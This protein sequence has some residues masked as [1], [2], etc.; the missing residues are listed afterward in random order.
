MF[1]RIGLS[2]FKLYSG[3]IS[4]FVFLWVLISFEVVPCAFEQTEDREL[5]EAEEHVFLFSHTQYYYLF[6][7]CETILL[8]WYSYCSF[9]PLLLN[10]GFLVYKAPFIFVMHHFKACTVQWL[11]IFTNLCSHHLYLIPEIFRHCWRI[12]LLPIF[13]SSLFCLSTFCVIKLPTLIT[14]WQWSHVVYGLCVFLL[15]LA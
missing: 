9:F 13:L 6:C 12:L 7:L 4:N 2:L 11:S 14:L 1:G 3:L 5:T 15:Q 10:Y 8:Y